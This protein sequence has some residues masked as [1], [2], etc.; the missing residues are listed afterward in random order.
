MMK[1]KRAIKCTNLQSTKKI[2]MKRSITNIKFSLT[3]RGLLNR[4]LRMFPMI[5]FSMISKKP[6]QSQMLMK[7]LHKLISIGN[8]MMRL[9]QRS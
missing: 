3:I 9:N 7:N 1:F 8:K 2:R 4:K 6:I 5:L